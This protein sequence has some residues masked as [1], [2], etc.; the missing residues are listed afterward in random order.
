MF[1]LR[2]LKTTFYNY[3]FLRIRNSTTDHLQKSTLLR[4]NEDYRQY[5]GRPSVCFSVPDNGI[6]FQGLSTLCVLVT[7]I[8][9]VVANVWSNARRKR[10]TS[11]DIDHTH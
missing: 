2:T 4:R 1:P 9:Q 8:I 5:Y 11:D 7:D 3:S 6:A 10:P